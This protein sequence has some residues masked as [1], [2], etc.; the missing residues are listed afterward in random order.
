MF[1]IVLSGTLD[2]QSKKPLQRKKDTDKGFQSPGITAGLN[3]ISGLTWEFQIHDRNGQLSRST[4]ILSAGYSSRYPEYESVVRKDSLYYLEHQ[5][6][7]THGIGASGSL[8]YY[9][10][11]DLT[12]AYWSIGIGGHVFFRNEQK[13]KTMNVT[14][15]FGYKKTLSKNLFLN[16]QAGACLMGSPFKSSSNADFN[17]FYICF[18]TGLQYKIM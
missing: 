3:Q 12:G 16:S 11:P 6:E 8:I 2:A 4:V 17:G 1:A 7:W 18:Q 13:F 10:R 14:A 9:F 5:R 15:M